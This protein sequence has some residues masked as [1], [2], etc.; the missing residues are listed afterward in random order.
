LA[1]FREEKKTY[2]LS[3]L[4]ESRDTADSFAE[5]KPQAAGSPRNPRRGAAF[6][7]YSDRFSGGALSGRLLKETGTLL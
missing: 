6:G 1:E 5:G 4:N 7:F 3:G 2:R